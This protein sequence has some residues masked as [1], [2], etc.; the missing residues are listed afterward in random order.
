MTT[1]SPYIINYLS[2]AIQADCLKS[3]IKSNGSLM[4]KLNVIV[5]LKSTVN[6]N[7]ISVY[8]LDEK[9]GV[10]KKLNSYDG[11]PSDKNLLNESL[12]E[13]NN[14]FDSLLEIEQEL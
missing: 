5:P 11:I 1:H 4:N 6:S 8:Q 9:T 12:A 3:K 13:G 2:I 14:L 7:D 10:I